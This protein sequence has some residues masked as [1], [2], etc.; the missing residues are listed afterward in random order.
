[1]TIIAVDA[2][3]DADDGWAAG[4]YP[5]NGAK[6]TNPSAKSGNAIVVAGGFFLHVIVLRNLG[7]IRALALYQ[8]P[9]QYILPYPQ[10]S[11]CGRVAWPFSRLTSSNFDLMSQFG[12]ICVRRLIASVLIPDILSADIQR[13]ANV[14]MR[15][16]RR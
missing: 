7:E 16:G 2:A 6:I 13:G 1:M 14:T 5:T 9:R 3:S 4:S 15:S 12:R 10:N 8:K 11:Y